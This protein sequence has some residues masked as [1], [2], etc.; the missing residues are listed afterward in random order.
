[1]KLKLADLACQTFDLRSEK[2][3]P[4]ILKLDH[5]TDG[6]GDLEFREGLTLLSGLAIR[7]LLATL[8]FPMSGGRIFTEHGATMSHLSCEGRIRNGFAGEVR[9]SIVETDGLCLELEGVRAKGHM[10]AEGLLVKLDGR[11]GRIEVSTLT[12][13]DAQCTVGGLLI[14]IGVIMVGGLKVSWDGKGRPHIAATR[15]H[16]KDLHLQHGSAGVDIAT[17]ELPEGLKIEQ[18]VEIEQ[19][20]IGA[21]EITVDDFRRK[22]KAEPEPEADDDDP[23]KEP[24][25]TPVERATFALDQGV[26]DT[27]NGQMDVDLTVSVTMPVIGKRIAV[28]KFRIPIEGGIVDYHDF[29]RGLAD[30]EDAFLDIRVRGNKLVLE[31]DIPLIPGLRKPIVTWLLEPGEVELASKSL[32]RLRTL[33]KA[34]MASSDEPDDDRAKK[35]R[36]K[37]HR[38]DF[39]NFAVHL[40]IDETAI[41]KSGHGSLRA[42]LDELDLEGSLRYDPDPEDERRPTVLTATATGLGTV[43]DKLAI[44]GHVV[45]GSLTI[46]SVERFR[47]GFDEL[48]PTN[49]TLALKNISISDVNYDLEVTG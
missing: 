4:T 25:P 30:L 3:P 38:L 12:L 42:H 8:E 6:C 32:V 43:A 14:R 11:G 35:S 37:L 13:K 48:K 31:R 22:A 36:V 17:I 2:V 39:D 18:R 49:M 15:A 10:I 23:P 7:T 47:L 24:G 26:L 9:S 1:M 40:S 34:R 16:A 33:P 19:I 45:S 46:A 27:V 41:L 29:E 28:H 5:I 21:V 20:R 44:A